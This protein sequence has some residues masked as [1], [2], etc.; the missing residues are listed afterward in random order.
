MLNEDRLKTRQRERK[1]INEY[2]I[3]IFNEINVGNPSLIVYKISFK[4]SLK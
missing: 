3:L 1:V 2:E 4:A